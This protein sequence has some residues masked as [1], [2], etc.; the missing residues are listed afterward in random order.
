MDDSFNAETFKD[1]WSGIKIRLFWIRGLGRGRMAPKLVDILKKDSE[2]EKVEN[3][4]DWMAENTY[5]DDNDLPTQK[6]YT[7][8]ENKIKD[9]GDFG[10]IKAY[11]MKY[12]NQISN[13]K[14]GDN[15]TGDG[16]GDGNR[17]GLRP[18][19]NPN[20]SL[21]FINRTNL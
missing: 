19:I 21:Y 4:F 18:I 2:V 16:G 11:L 12:R 6:L 8:F 17:E 15:G 3:F 14:N 1:Y 5:I 20:P 9:N 13:S 7:V 10:R